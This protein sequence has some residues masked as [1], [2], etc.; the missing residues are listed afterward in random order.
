MQYCDLILLLVVA[1]ADPPEPPIQPSPP[2]A[3]L[4][5][6]Q[7]V[8]VA[9]GQKCVLVAETTAKKVTWKT[10]AGADSLSLDGKRLAVWAIPGTYTF[11]AMVPSGDDVISKEI[12][13]TVT[14]PRPP[15]IDPITD[16]LLAPAQAAYSLD[17]SATKAADRVLLMNTYKALA[18]GLG[19][20]TT[21][22]ELATLIEKTREAR[23]DG[24]LAT[25]RVIFGKE[26]DTLIPKLAS[27]VLTAEH[28]AKASS[29]L[30]RYAAIL[31]VIK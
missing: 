24:R 6:G 29:E 19:T 31:E 9:V 2:A 22:G 11:T 16:A 3:T 1:V 21:A 20:V 26:F 5:L 13:L 23:I 12:I 27:T 25:V 18:A 7:P 8:T 10:P 30:N 4:E 28:K 15:P 14:G 17:T